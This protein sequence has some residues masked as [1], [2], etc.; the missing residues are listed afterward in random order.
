MLQKHIYLNSADAKFGNSM[1]VPTAQTV[2][3]LSNFASA[4]SFMCLCQNV[5]ENC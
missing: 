5:G 4:L 1:V 2:I 3:L